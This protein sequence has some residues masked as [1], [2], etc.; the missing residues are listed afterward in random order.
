M[1][2][3]IDVLD[4]LLYQGKLLVHIENPELNSPETT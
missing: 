4:E 2:Y 3:A 1:L